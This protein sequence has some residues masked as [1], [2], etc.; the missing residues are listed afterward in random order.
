M[1]L[2]LAALLALAFLMTS[3]REARAQWCAHYEPYVYNCG[4]STFQQCLATI[5][6]VG[7]V[8][9]R[10]YRAMSR[11]PEAEPAPPMRRKSKKRRR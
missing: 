11:T 4:F 1:K 7:G 8:C 2:K 9:S 6:G 10:D 3:H 5:S